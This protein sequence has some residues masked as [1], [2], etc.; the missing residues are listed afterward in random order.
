MI[1]LNKVLLWAALFVTCMGVGVAQANE[2]EVK[3]GFSAKFP[4][5]PVQSVTKIPN[6][7]LYEVIVGTDVY[8]TDSKLQYLVE[9]S[10][11]DLKTQENLTAERQRELK[12]T[13]IAWGDLPLDL[14]FKKVKGK[15]E[16]KIA[17]FSDPDCPYCK[18]LE[19]S[20][21]DV[22]NITI[23]TFL[24]PLAD[25]HPQAVEKSKS[26][27]CSTDRNKAWDD[28]MLKGVQPSARKDC[29]H[30]VDK[31]LAYAKK[32][33]ISSTPTLVFAT[34]KRLNGAYPREAIEEQLNGS[35]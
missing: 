6:I 17:V 4:K 13:P 19:T 35:K 7:D 1:K 8:Y 29:D 5:A 27:W 21:K 3:K 30:P 16:R 20:L 26:I 10:L 12:E 24:F 11:I 22:D 18:R 34:G 14:A 32:K 28:Y 33:N 25:L 23:Y 2:D 9:G 15:G 31:V